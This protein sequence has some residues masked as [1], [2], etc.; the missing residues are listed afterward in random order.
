MLLRKCKKK[1]KKVDDMLT[2]KLSH[3]N[4]TKALNEQSIWNLFYG[5]FYELDYSGCEENYFTFSL[6]WPLKQT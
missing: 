2:R 3:N 5:P 4:L 1:S 6:G